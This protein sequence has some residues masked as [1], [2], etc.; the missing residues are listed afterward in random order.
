MKSE[1]R[2]GLDVVL[3]IFLVVCLCEIE[4]CVA[5]AGG[6]KSIHRLKSQLFTPK[7]TDEL[8]EQHQHGQT[9]RQEE[10]EEGILRLSMEKKILEV[11]AELKAESESSNGLVSGLKCLGCKAA[12]KLLQFYVERKGKPEKVEKYFVPICKR[13]IDKKRYD[14]KLVCPGLVKTYGPDVFFIAA[15]LSIDPQAACEA[16]G[17][18]GLI[19]PL[20]EDLE[21]DKGEQILNEI[22]AESAVLINEVNEDL[23]EK[24]QQKES[25]RL[26]ILH[27]SDF[28][29]D[30]YYVPGTYSKCG[31]ILCCREESAMYGSDVS[32]AGSWGDY[33][34]CD[35]PK[36]TIESLMVHVTSMKDKVDMIFYTGDNPPHDLYEESAK[37]QLNATQETVDL[38]SKYFPKTPIYPVYGNHESFPANLFFT[39]RYTWLTNGLAREWHGWIDET[40]AADVRKGGFYSTLI[41]PGL[42]LLS[43][44]TQT[45]YRDN[46]YT[47]LYKKYP[48]EFSLQWKWVVSTLNQAIRNRERIIIIGHVPP[49]INDATEHFGLVYKA[50]VKRYRKHIVGH[51][52]GHVHGDQFQTIRSPIAGKALGIIFNGPS[53]TTWGSKN[54][55]FRIYELAGSQSFELLD[56]KQYYLNISKANENI[57]NFSVDLYNK[58]SD[59]IAYPS[60]EVQ[61]S[62]L[63]EYGLKDMSPE[64]WKDLCYSFRTNE[65]LL[66]MYL[67]HYYSL[68]PT[69]MFGNG[70]K[71]DHKC[72]SSTVCG[73]YSGSSNQFSACR[74]VHSGKNYNGENDT[75]YSYVRRYINHFANLM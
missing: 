61:Y 50:I 26:R 34:Y 24:K 60:W 55:T 16:I 33:G 54:P 31:S 5:V 63:S 73:C 7:E 2:L 65:T 51:F 41:K 13:Y 28:H 23:S 27:L 44:N 69:A 10:E 35:V 9:S 36:W 11:D 71:C 66:H 48:K 6:E 38:L 19:K 70:K 62:A 46:Y 15:E 18:C 64:S 29:Y 56:Y 49:S 20:S 39:P 58:N 74:A 22:G 75:I 42:R 32:K 68:S 67:N 8:M 21:F 14:P 59:K 43:I 3:L 57:E 72:Y 12:V 47:L 4:V 1:R 25:D 45:G 17:F 37:R 30:K 52:F 40:A 53:V